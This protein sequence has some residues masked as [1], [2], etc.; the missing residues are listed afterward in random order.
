MFMAFLATDDS[1]GDGKSPAFQATV[2]LRSFAT[3]QPTSDSSDSADNDSQT[4]AEDG[5]DNIEV[6]EEIK[7]VTEKDLTTL[8]E[9]LAA[10]KE[11]NGPII[12]T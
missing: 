5:Q 11:K 9:Y 8:E 3:N 6:K 10:N 7:T 1:T 12:I 4:T 2:Y